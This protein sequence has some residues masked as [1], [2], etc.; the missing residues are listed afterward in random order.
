MTPAQTFEAAITSSM[1]KAVF[2]AEH[3]IHNISI[4]LIARGHVLLQGYPGVGKTLMARSL[5]A[6]MGSE[7]K[8]IQCTADLM[9]AD[10][11]GIHIFNEETRKF[12][13]MQGPLFADIVLVDEINRTGPKTQSAMLQAMEERSISID[14]QVYPLPDEFF[15][16]ATQNPYEFEG[17][18][19]LP[20]AQLDRFLMQL[21]I[22]YPATE[23]ELQVIKTYDKPQQRYTDKLEGI[24]AI[25]DTLLSSARQQAS[26]IHVSESMYQY[27]HAIANASRAH[28][29]VSLGLSTRGVLALMRCARCEAALRAREFVSPDDIKAIA[30]EVLAHRIILTPD[31]NLEGIEANNIVDNILAQVEVPRE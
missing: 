1:G 28:P 15:V 26:N 19:P 21:E 2:G 16:I 7:F 18:Y 13:L 27:C 8:R 14:R 6:A 9:P 10:M 11:T 4:A 20:E 31:A 23:A 25:T 24:E 29:H 17:T 22:S 30:K 12:S 3:I 5:A